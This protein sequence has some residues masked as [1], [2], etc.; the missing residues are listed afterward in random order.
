MLPAQL[1]CL[2]QFHMRPVIDHPW[3]LSSEA[4]IQLQQT[5]AAKVSQ[6][7]RLGTVRL[8]AG[9]DVAYTKNSDILTAAVVL[10]DASTLAVVKTAMAGDVARFPYVPGLFS[11][12]ELPPVIQA[13]GKLQ[14]T[15]DLVI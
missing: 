11:F 12:R 13:L 8:V 9:A 15:P 4:A 7:D 10:I 5:L 6:E 14:N 3:A 2:A 1:H